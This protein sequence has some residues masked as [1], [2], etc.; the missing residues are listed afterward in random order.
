MDKKRTTEGRHVP[1]Q[2]ARSYLPW[3]VAVVGILALLFWG[4]S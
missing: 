4:V 1:G 3:A 2:D